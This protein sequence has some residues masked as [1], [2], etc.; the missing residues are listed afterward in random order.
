MADGMA[1]KDFANKLLTKGNPA[2]AILQRLAQSS[3][4][5]SVTPMRDER[6]EAEF[7]E[8]GEP[9]KIESFVKH[10]QPVSDHTQTHTASV[11]F[12]APEGVSEADIMEYILDIRNALN[13]KVESFKWSVTARGER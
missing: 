8:A 2:G 13:V 9:P 3:P 6:P 10:E 11:G 5:V 1:L 4:S 12:S 7:S